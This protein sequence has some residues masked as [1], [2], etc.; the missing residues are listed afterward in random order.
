MSA[1]YFD[2]IRE[3]KPNTYNH[4]LRLAGRKRQRARHQTDGATFSRRPCPPYA[5]GCAAWPDAKAPPQIP[6]QKGP[7][8]QRPRGIFGTATRKCARTR[9]PR[10]LATTWCAEL[11]RTLTMVVISV[12]PTVRN[13][14]LAAGFA[15]IEEDVHMASARAMLERRRS[16]SPGIRITHPHGHTEERREFRG[17]AAEHTRTR[18]RN[19]DL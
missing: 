2:L 18:V 13:P 16:I 12:G 3:M 1:R 7:G 11:L 19:G 15:G 17:D 6:A 14:T 8:A 10:A 4:R 9:L 5:S